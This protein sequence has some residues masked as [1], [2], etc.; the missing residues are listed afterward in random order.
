MKLHLQGGNGS[1][2]STLLKVLLGNTKPSGGDWH[3]NTATYYLDQHFGLVDESLSVLDNIGLLC[4]GVQQSNARTLLAGIGFRRDD[5]HRL[6]SYLS[7]G[8]KMKLSMLMVSHQ[9]EQPLLLL[10]EPDN[11]LDLD[12]KRVLASALNHYQGAFVI[13]SHD[14]EFVQECGGNQTAMLTT[15]GK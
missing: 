1:G 13:V 10:D 7:G 15:N 2:K 9:S 3:M 5:V 6:A 12:S 4:P 14:R 8:E 11:H